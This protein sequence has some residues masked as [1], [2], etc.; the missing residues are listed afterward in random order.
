M[1]PQ[2][3]F[4][5]GGHSEPDPCPWASSKLWVF[6]LTLIQN[7]KRCLSVLLECDQSLPFVSVPL[8]TTTL[9]GTSSIIR[10]FIHST[11]IECLLYARHSSSVGAKGVCKRGVL[12]I[13]PLPPRPESICYM[14]PCEAGWGGYTRVSPWL[15][16]FRFC[17]H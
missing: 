5:D 10:S 13:W 17:P 11:N 9:C 12:A 16:D 14:L 15:W 7:H 1:L 3:V 8:P 4:P 2:E 6:L